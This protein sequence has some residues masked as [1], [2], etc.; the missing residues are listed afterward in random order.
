MKSKGNQDLNNN[1][2]V[3]DGVRERMFWLPVQKLN[4]Y[5]LFPIFFKEKLFHISDSVIH[6]KTEEYKRN[7]L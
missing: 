4:E 7:K 1:S 2:Y 6:I 3:Y 5:K